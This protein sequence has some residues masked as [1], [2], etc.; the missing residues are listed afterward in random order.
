MGDVGRESADITVHKA[1]MN[2][3]LTKLMMS[4]HADITV[5]KADM[6]TIINNPYRQL[7]VYS[8]SPIKERVANHNRLKAFL[9]VGKQVDFPLDLPQYLSPI[10]RTSESVAQAEASLALPNE[11]LRYAQFWFMKASPLDEVAFNHLF[12]GNMEGA[13]DIWMKK[14]CASS[15]QNRI[16]CALIKED[17]S[18]AIYCTGT[19]YSQ[20]LGQFVEVVIGKGSSVST[21]SL[22]FDFIDELCEEVGCKAI[23]PYLTDETWKSHVAEK[24]VNP[25]IEKIQSAIDV[26]KSSRGKGSTARY[27]AGVKL[28]KDTTEPLQQLKTFL[29][30]TDLQYQVI[31]DKLGLE[32]L[33]C[34]IDYYNDSDDNDAAYK[35][36]ELQKYAESIVVGKMAVERCK[37]NVRILEDIIS[38]LPPLEVMTNHKNIQLAL[39]KF[40]IQPELIIY[41]IQLIKSCVSDIVA[42]KEKLGRD[43]QYYLAISTTI[44]NAAL[45][46]LIG[47][48]NEAQQKDFETLKSALISAWRAQLYMDKFDLESAYKNGRFKECRSALH[49]I[50][51]NCKGFEDSRNSYMYEFG[52]GW[53]NNLDALDVDLRTDDENFA[54]CKTLTSY[55]LYLQK[56]PA[57]KHTLEA[58]SKIIELRYKDCKTLADYQNFLHDYPN[59]RYRLK[60]LAAIDKLLREEEERKARITRQEKAISACVT[61][62][63]VLTLYAKEKSASI[64]INKC[65]NKGFELAKTKKDFQNVLST[66]GTYSSGGQKAKAKIEELERIRKA[67][68]KK[69]KWILWIGIPILI[70]VSIY[71]VWGV[72]GIVNT[73]LAIAVISGFIAFGAMKTDDGCA[74]FFI[75]AIIAAIFGLLGYGLNEIAD[76]ISDKNDSKKLYKEIINNPTEKACADY[77]KKFESINIE[78]ANQVRGIWLSLLMDEAK[79]FDYASYKGSSLSYGNLSQTTNPIHKLQE[80]IE[81]NDET[82]CQ[83]KARLFIKS[84]C[85]SLYNVADRK[86]T[87]L[88]WKQYQRVVPTNYVR[89]SDK[90]MEIIENQAWS[91]ESKAWRQATSE[92]SISAYEKYKSLYPNGAHIGICEKK[93][94][95]LEVSRI[96]AGEHGTLPAMDRTGYGGG[97]T[98]YITVTN[99]TS[100]T[101]TILYSGSDSKKL[102]IGAGKTKFVRLKNGQY[103]VAASVSASN[104]SNY[105]GTENLLGGDY[106][107]DYYIRTYRY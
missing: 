37:E 42:I 43:N 27:N 44:V 18:N 69:L 34:G 47:E 92:N 106:S 91:T 89:D 68:G 85:D 63:E 2:T 50:I 15:L 66:F 26:A 99:S 60:A 58:K 24:S 56:F 48:V 101:L 67:R 31:T 7:G 62:N 57:G 22:V 11:Q 93:L 90:K 76:N 80:F 8:N 20:Y 5:H 100:Y 65:S 95:D 19:L 72:Q 73:F 78:K 41:S 52:C 25:L 55:K 82:D 46:K 32:I 28:M 1:D 9:K 81:Q 71:I 14:N 39:A 87:V 49:N 6:N 13:I 107:V 70:L 54:S 86:S 59:N 77:I 83:N 35:A 36:I 51:E 96:Y 23:L 97:S 30:T 16:V 98:S 12:A 21:D 75:F 33:Q 74:P 17:Y 103:R 105:A 40:A 84:I 53:C 3:T 64:D 94:I 45:E 4:K 88:G 10:D 79:R 29:S 61:L 38:K 104:V 102:V